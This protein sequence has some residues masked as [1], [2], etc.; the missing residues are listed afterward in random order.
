MKIKLKTR[1][2]KDTTLEAFLK[3]EKIHL[4]LEYDPNEDETN[5]FQVCTRPFIYILKSNDTNH[6][7]QCSFG[8]CA[9]LAVRKFIENLKGNHFNFD[10]TSRYYLCP[11]NLDWDG[12]LR[13][14]V[15]Q[16]KTQKKG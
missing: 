11:N 7:M 1:K 6:L 12:I 2:K 14:R 9:D 13:V 8:R 5:K 16:I 15:K 10:G 4:W 3:E